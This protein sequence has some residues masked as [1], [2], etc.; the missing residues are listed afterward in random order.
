MKYIPN[1]S[2]WNKNETP[3]HPG[4][5]S[6]QETASDV[7]GFGTFEEIRPQFINP[8]PERPIEKKYVC[9]SEF[10]S[11]MLKEWNNQIGWKTL[12]S[13]LKLLGYEVVSISKEK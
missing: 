6:L 5:T 7:L 10:A 11:G 12:V 8:N 2:I 3:Q 1:L 9:I 13:E 4:K